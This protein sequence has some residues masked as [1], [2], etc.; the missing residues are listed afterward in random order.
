[1][2]QTGMIKPLHGLRGGAALTVVIG[3]Y[4]I[5]TATPSLGVVLFFMISGF[6]IGKLY[7][8]RPFENEE[9]AN[10]IVA[11]F[12]RVYPLFAQVVIAVGLLNYMVP[13]ADIFHLTPDQILPHLLLFGSAMTIWTICTE[14][15]FYLLFIAIWWIRSKGCGI[16]WI[17]IPLLIVSFAYA[18]WLGAE[19]G[20]TDIASY[21]HVFMLGLAIAALTGNPHPRL[22]AA[23]RWALPLF[24]LLYAAVFFAYPRMGLAE[25]AIYIHPTVL[26]ICSGLLLSSLAAGPHWLNRLLSLPPAIWLGEISFGVYLLHRPVGWAMSVETPNQPLNKLGAVALTL[27]L[28]QIAYVLIEKPSR[29]A[30]RGW[31]SRLIARYKPAPA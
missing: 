23:A 6:L 17:V 1:M 25:R 21:L 10:Y 24:A 4:G 9:I 18:L 30:L 12:A 7:V 14:F 16:R 15:Q 19:A 5:V 8:E 27:I 26:L 11:R 31:G 3:H 20:R 29:G 2:T 28:A 13:D 22:Q